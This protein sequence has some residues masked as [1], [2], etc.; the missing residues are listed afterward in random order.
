M[1]WATSKL[2]SKPPPISAGSKLLS[3]SLFSVY[4]LLRSERHIIAPDTDL[5]VSFVHFF[6]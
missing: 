3:V 1:G 2:L 4:A 5:C 6:M